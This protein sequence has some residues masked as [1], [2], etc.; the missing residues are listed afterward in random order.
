MVLDE[1]KGESD[2]FSFTEDH[3]LFLIDKYRALLLK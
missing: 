3:I 1:L 2:D